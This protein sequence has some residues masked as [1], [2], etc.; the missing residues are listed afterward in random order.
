MADLPVKLG[1]MDAVPPAVRYRIRDVIGLLGAGPLEGVA[2]ERLQRLLDEGEPWLGADPSLAEV[3]YWML[4]PKHGPELRRQ[5]CV[6][7]TMFPSVDTVERVAAVALDPATPMPVREQ[8]IW[9]LG[10]RQLRCLHPSTRWTTEAVQLADEA[11]IKLG[12]AATTAGKVA[13]EQLPLAMRHIEWEGASAIFARAP[14]L[15]GE[16]IESYAS[17]AFARVLLVCLE[18]IPPRH[19]LRAIRLVGAVLGDECIPLMLAKA[20]QASVDER[21]EMLFMVISLA[22]EAKLGVLEDA[23]KGMKFVDLLRQRAKWHLQNPR[24]VPTVRGLR[25]ARST[26]MMPAEQRQKACA[27]AADDLGVLTKFARHPEAYLYTMWGWMVRGACDPVRARELVAAHPESQRLVRDL[28]VE[29]LAKRGRVKS[30]SAAA[31][32]LQSADQG[33]L[34]LAIYGRPLAALE[35]A[36]TARLHT[37]ELVCARVLACY[38][39]GRPDLAKRLLAEDLP[40]S[41]IVDDAGLPPFPGPHE[42]W[43][44]E[45]APASR[46]AIVALAGGLDAV[47]GLAKAAPLESEPDAASLESIQAVVR[48]L[49]RGLPGSTVYLAGEFKYLDKG[50][51]AKAVEAAGARLV[52]GPFPGTDYYVHGDWCLV[53]TIAQLERQGARRLRRGELPGADV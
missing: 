9:T 53:Q 6:W 5:G 24:V 39:A 52:N 12:D 11:L 16:A 17:K 26:A 33:A 19:R 8:A 28:Y 36:A 15:W 31:Q 20:S 3:G 43:L 37:P 7:L 49:G 42:Q 50:K 32:T 48:R 2:S 10:Y 29:D 41:E 1:A 40:P 18:D 34:H 25:V 14:G 23:I 46:P 21:L 27:Q 51:I 13:S 4:Q 22:G 38:R 44:I 47:V 30:L 45:H 35:L